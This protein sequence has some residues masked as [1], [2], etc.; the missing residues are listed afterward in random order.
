MDWDFAI[1]KNREALARVLAML[2]AMAGLASWDDMFAQPAAPAVALR[3]PA[4][5]LTRRLYRALLKLMLPAEAA[6]RRLVIM[7]ARDLKV[8]LPRLRAIPPGK[9]TMAAKRPAALLRLALPLVDALPAWPMR[10]RPFCLRRGVP[11]I[12]VPGFGEPF[13][14]PRRSP[15]DLVDASRLALRLE[16]LRRALD[17]LPGQAQRFARWRARHMPGPGAAGP[18]EG[19]AKFLRNW[20]LRPGRPPGW[21][22]KSSHAVHEALNNVHGLALWALEPPDT[23]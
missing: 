17:D 9:P 10:P 8:V 21:R 12:S 19:R 4:P 3:A 20:P 18:P 13:P 2:F 23:S 15:E 7:A 22:R 1:E 16:T 11:R 6:V 5:M 14:I